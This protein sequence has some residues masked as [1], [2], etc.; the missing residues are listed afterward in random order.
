MKIAQCQETIARESQRALSLI[1][2]RISCA[3]GSRRWDEVIQWQKAKRQA[4]GTVTLFQP[5]R[6]EDLGAFVEI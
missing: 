3:I 1:D 2:H 5:L 4:L 6:P